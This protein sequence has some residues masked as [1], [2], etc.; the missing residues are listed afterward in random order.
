MSTPARPTHLIPAH[1]KS[2]PTHLIPA[3]QKPIP[4]HLIPAHQKPIPTHL[5]PAHP[6]VPASNVCKGDLGLKFTATCAGALTVQGTNHRNHPVTVPIANDGSMH[7]VLIQP[8]LYGD[9]LVYHC[10]GGKQQIIK[11][12]NDDCPFIDLD[13]TQS[14]GAVTFQACQAKGSLSSCAPGERW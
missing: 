5:I 11:L 4:T 1:Q 3:H 14:N 8:G 10:D 13:V 9:Q 6:V 12:N 7:A 2:I